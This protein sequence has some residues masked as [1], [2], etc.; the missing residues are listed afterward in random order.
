M[1]WMQQLQGTPQAILQNDELM[2]ALLPAVRADFTL[3]ETYCFIEDGMLDC[4]LSVFGGIQ[5]EEIKRDDL[6]AWL[7]LT[8][9]PSVVRMLPGDH[10]FLRSSQDVL[11][12]AIRHDL[13]SFS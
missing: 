8:S 12:N 7:E 11:F 9:G 13:L 3:A 2:K 6:L 1:E 10:F 4:P 5:D